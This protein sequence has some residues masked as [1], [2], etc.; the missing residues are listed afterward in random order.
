MRRA[1]KRPRGPVGPE[2]VSNDDLGL[3]M[4]FH[5]LLEKFQYWLFATG[6]CSEATQDLACVIGG[7]PQELNLAVGSHENLVEA[8]DDAARARHRRGDSGR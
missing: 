8:A 6:L 4:P 1:R 5:H 3:T 7:A 2:L